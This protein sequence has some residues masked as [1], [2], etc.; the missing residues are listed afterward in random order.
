MSCR[1]HHTTQWQRKLGQ[2][3]CLRCQVCVLTVS[4]LQ[5]A[6]M[7]LTQ[8]AFEDIFL[9][10]KF[11]KQGVCL[12]S[13]HCRTGQAACQVCLGQLHSWKV[14]QRLPD[15]WLSA[16][17]LLPHHLAAMPSPSPHRVT[18]ASGPRGH[19]GQ[20]PNPASKPYFA[21]QCFRQLGLCSR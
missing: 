15:Q 9:D 8:C 19:P 16:S 13:F 14:F 12:Q 6:E 10:S 7:V 1:Q 5:A 3:C 11:L 2:S 21:R 18:G 17:V 4:G 20:R